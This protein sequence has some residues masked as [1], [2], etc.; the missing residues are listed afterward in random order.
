MELVKRDKKEE[1]LS[2]NEILNLLKDGENKYWITEKRGKTDTAK[3]YRS[4]RNKNKTIYDK[5]MN[6]G[7]IEDDDS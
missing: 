4:L 1:G 6:I 3:L 7:Y 2:K 5:F